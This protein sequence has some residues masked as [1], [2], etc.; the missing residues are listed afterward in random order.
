MRKQNLFITWTAL[1]PN[2][3]VTIASQDD[4]VRPNV[5]RWIKNFTPN[6]SYMNASNLFAWHISIHM[7]QRIPKKPVSPSQTSTKSHKFS[8]RMSLDIRFTTEEKCCRLTL[9]VMCVLGSRM[10][11][12]TGLSFWVNSQRLKNYLFWKHFSCWVQIQ[13][14]Q[15]WIRVHYL[16]KIKYEKKKSLYNP[17]P[18]SKRSMVNLKLLLCKM[19]MEHAI[20]WHIYNALCMLIS[21]QKSSLVD[22]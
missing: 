14:V 7:H 13:G 22:I 20:I 4:K 15:N 16:R 5:I 3:D 8:D 10:I 17:T 19:W 11:S 6:A 2:F 18:S 9:Q 12:S 1:T 21:N